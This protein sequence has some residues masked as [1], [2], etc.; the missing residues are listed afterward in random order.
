[1]NRNHIDINIDDKYFCYILGLIWA[2]G[3]VSLGDG[4]RVSI[5]MVEDD[6]NNIYDILFRIYKW[7][8]QVDIPKN[9]I[10]KK[11]VRLSVTDKRFKSFLIDNDYVEK[12]QKS[13]TKILSKI[14]KY[15]QKYFLRGLFDGDGCFFYKRYKNGAVCRIAS[16]TSSYEQD[17]SCLTKMLIYINC[18]FTIRKVI[19]N[20][21]KNHK[22]S[23]LTISR[24]DIIRFGNY[25]YED[26]FGLK[27]KYDKYLEIKNSYRYKKCIKV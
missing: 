21:D 22:S 5:K 12:S 7:K 10:W 24:S 25:L 9:D 27:R 4:N 1:M 15:N 11:S 17:W 3:T 14:P 2:D 23:V 13:P 8:T 26:N 19:N 16:I 18:K 20:K 6:V